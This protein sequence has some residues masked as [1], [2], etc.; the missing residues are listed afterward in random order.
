[1]RLTFL[2]TD[3]EGGKC[4]TLYRTDR[5]TI[6]V[7]GYKVT[8]AALSRTSATWRTTRPW[9]RSPVSCCATRTKAPD[10][11]DGS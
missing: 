11:W 7:Q 10:R 2:G 1:M 9:S 5:D 6:V 4:P 8:D 3:S